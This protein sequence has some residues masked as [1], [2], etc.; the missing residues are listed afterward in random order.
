MW[1]EGAAFAVQNKVVGAE[2]A[3]PIHDYQGAASGWSDSYG[4]KS[5]RDS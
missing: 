1:P 4:P 2:P 5:S 3:A